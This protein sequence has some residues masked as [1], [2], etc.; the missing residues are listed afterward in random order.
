M[1]DVNKNAL[2]EGAIDVSDAVLPASMRTMDIEADFSNA[3]SLSYCS[4]TANT[5]EE[6]AALFAAMSNPTHKLADCINMEIDFKNV[7]VEMIDIV[8]RNDGQI[9]TMARTVLMDEKGESYQCVST[10]V[11]EG[12]KKL[13]RVYGRPESW[14]KPLR[15]KILQTKVENGTMLSFAVVPPKSK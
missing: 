6:K 14:Q 2:I 8:D 3:G 5:E 13:F 1:T 11:Y 12:L 15:I 10:G 4:M 7:Y 9:K